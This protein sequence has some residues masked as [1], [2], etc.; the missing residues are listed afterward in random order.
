MRGAKMQDE[1]ARRYSPSLRLARRVARVCL[2]LL[3]CATLAPNVSRAGTLQGALARVYA[4]NPDL[5]QTRASVRA[6]DE[7]TT[8]ALAGL[9]PKAGVTATAGPD[10]STIRIPAGRTNTGQRAYYSDEY[11]GK[12]RGATLTISQTLY[13][14]GAALSAAAQAKFEH[15]CGESRTACLGAIAVPDRRQRLHERFARHRRA[16]TE[17]AQR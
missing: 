4:N 12:P 3:A 14:G 13:D 10:Y 8:K 7:E 2:A 6:R 1:S 16:A 17:A 9:R 15:L 11:L 5:N